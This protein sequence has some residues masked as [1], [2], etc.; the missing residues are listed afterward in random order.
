M[1]KNLQLGRGG[2][3]G[4]TEGWIPKVK[5]VE[6]PSWGWLVRVP[7]PRAETG[8]AVGLTDGNDQETTGRELNDAELAEDATEEGA[9]PDA[10]GLDA[11]AVGTEE[12]AAGADEGWL[13]RAKRWPSWILCA[14]TATGSA[15]A[16]RTV[17][18]MTARD[19]LVL[20]RLVRTVCDECGGE[21][22]AP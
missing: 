8:M 21:S 9:E 6:G 12:L 7:G 1:S 15:T 13:W 3:E 14:E 20:R 22:D 10:T 17:S 19:R 18:F 2:A 4:I 11:G 5:V 16:P